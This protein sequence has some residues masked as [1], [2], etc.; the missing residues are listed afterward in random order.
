M[1]PVAATEHATQDDLDV[2]EAEE[3]RQ[4]ISGD[5]NAFRSIY[6]RHHPRIAILAAYLMSNSDVADVVQEVFVQA[7][8]KLHTWRGSG[9]FGAWLRRLA[10][11]EILARRS[12]YIR[13][14]FREQDIGHAA[15]ITHSGQSLDIRI[16]LQAA[17]ATLPRRA[18]EV[19]VLH[20]IE[21]FTHEEIAAM[22]GIRAQTSRSQLCRARLLLRKY[23]EGNR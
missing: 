8:R 2:I 9:P 5:Q 15:S 11:R 18:R 23:L 3:V 21:A 12:S 7:W 6:T 17:V 14:E 1:P 20:D 22:T 19:F 10:V 4:A 16:D 13:S